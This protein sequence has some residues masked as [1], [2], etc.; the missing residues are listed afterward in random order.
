MSEPENLAPLAA[1]VPVSFRHSLRGRLLLWTVVLTGAILSALVLVNYLNF[2]ARLEDEAGRRATY[3]AESAAN[4]IDARLVK[5][6]VVIEGLARLFETR[7]VHTSFAAWRSLQTDTLRAHPEIQGLGLVLLPEY[8]PRDWPQAS[9]YAFRAADGTITLDSDDESYVAE[10]WFVLP[11]YLQHP[12]WSDP[13]HDPDAGFMVSY[14]IPLWTT[15]GGE[16][17]FVGV[18]IADVAIDW[19]DELIAKLPLGERGYGVLINRSGTF[20]SHPQREFVL[21]ESIFSI[22][23][24]TGNEA[25]RRV[26]QKLI[27]GRPGLVHWLSGPEKEETWLAWQP[28]RGTEWT[29][30]TVVSKAELYADLIR[31]SQSAMGLGA[32]GLVLLL[33]VIWFIAR[34][35]T[36]PVQA[37]NDAVGTLAGGDLDARLPDPVGRDEVAQLTRAFRGMRDSL[38]HY[39]A[40]LAV[41]TAARERMQAELNVARD[42]QMDL[43]P[44]SFAACRQRTDLDLFAIMEPALE[45]GGDFYDF[46]FIDDDRLLVAVADVSGKGVPAAL[47]MAV[48]RSFLRAE[49]KADA[50]PGRVLSRVNEALLESNPSLM[51][52]TLFCGVLRLSDGL[53]DYA[54]AGHNPP[55]IKR[56]D[57]RLESIA[58]RSGPAV[59]PLRGATYTTRQLSLAVGDGLLL[60]TDGVTEAMDGASQLYGEQRLADFYG[61]QTLADCRSTLN[62]L[63]ADIRQYA[64]GA[65]QSDDITLLMVRRLA[66]PLTRPTPTP[67]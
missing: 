42:I 13:Y 57:G 16:R 2:R 22:A 45:V 38:K 15:V 47:F 30:V 17:V 36:R 60:Y 14:S 21:N 33:L 8:A 20:I 27:S 19:L 5:V 18:A 55:L 49:F 62:G 56:A 66:P 35:I 1:T 51:F 29:A 43:L 37:L 46:F 12:V 11:R 10:D 63:L 7:S 52:V 6:E 40:D 41:T 23:E 9:P 25:M 65:E 58:A 50:D 61:G 39:I 48:T 59:G 54:N 4:E 3:L 26:G 32:A 34:S 53:F 67:V 28:L 64:A 24:E 31:L 44:K